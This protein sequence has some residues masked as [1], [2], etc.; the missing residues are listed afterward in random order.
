[1]KYTEL[2]LSATG[3]GDSFD[4]GEELYTL[5]SLLPIGVAVAKRKAPAKNAKRKAPAKNAKRKAPEKNAKQKAPAKNAKRKAPEKNAK[6]KAP[7]K[8]AKQKAPAKNAKRKA[9][10]KNYQQ[11]AAA[12]V[13][14]PTRWRQRRGRSPASSPAKANKVTSSPTSS[15]AQWRKK[16]CRSLVPEEATRLQEIMLCLSQE[17]EADSL[18]YPFAHRVCKEYVHLHSSNNGTG[19]HR[20]REI[21]ISLAVL[22]VLKQVQ[23]ASARRAFGKAAVLNTRMRPIVEEVFDMPGRGVKPGSKEW[24]KQ[25]A[26][27][28]HKLP[29]DNMVIRYPELEKASIQHAML[30]GD[31][32]TGFPV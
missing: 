10:E 17:G 15:P 2:R 32:A 25:M 4:T 6:R 24:L 31:A 27:N 14:S 28:P 29:Y 5:H 20:H 21:Y 16:T 9:P 3:L 12:T 11:K 26:E 23:P 1:M 7:E 8:N 19:I 18:F 22:A 30:Q 13:A